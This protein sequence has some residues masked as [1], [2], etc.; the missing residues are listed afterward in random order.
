MASKIN[1]HMAG[2]RKGE[3]SWTD[4][5]FYPVN[6]NLV[7]GAQEGPDEVFLVDV[8]GGKG[9]N[10]A[11]LHQ[12]YPNLPGQLILQD[13]KPVI[14]EAHRSTLDPKIVL[15]EHDFFTEQPIKGTQIK[16][17]PQDKI[18]SISHNYPL[19][20]PPGA[21]TYYIHS[22]LHDW[23]DP[24]A[25]KILIAL[26]NSMKKG[27]SKLLINEYVI[28]DR[29]AHWAMTGLDILM[30]ANFSAK[31]RTEQNWRS[32]LDTAGFRIVKIW[33]YEPGSESLIEAE[34]M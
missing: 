28:P 22:C 11:D 26:G 27:Y 10:L 17:S 12:K 20:Y 1:N 25:L 31:E 8:G 16:K 34:L 21:R 4:P 29:N 24:E 2:R 23:P 7:E 32:L 9:Q 6:E 14:D 18:L 30:M 19:T 5:G 15:M 33:T 13:R 3:T